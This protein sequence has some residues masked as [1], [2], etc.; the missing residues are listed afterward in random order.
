MEAKKKG[1]SIP[2]DF[3]LVGYDDIFFSKILESPLTAIRQPVYHMGR[4]SASMLMNMIEK[5]EFTQVTE[6]FVPELIVRNSTVSIK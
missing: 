6:I 3:S 2:K 1:M 4:K 5:K